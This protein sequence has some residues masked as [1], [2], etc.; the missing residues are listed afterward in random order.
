MI[1]FIVKTIISIFTGI[2]DL[3]IM[4]LCVILAILL[5]EKRWIEVPSFILTR[6]L[7]DKNM[8]L[9]ENK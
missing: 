4:D 1:N 2:I 6:M 3:L 8:N 9:T 5:W 7:W